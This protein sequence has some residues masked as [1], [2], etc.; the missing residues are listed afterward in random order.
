MS[1][2]V[3]F[4]IRSWPCKAFPVSVTLVDVSFMTALSENLRG[5]LFWS[6]DVLVVLIDMSC[7][8]VS[9]FSPIEIK[10]NKK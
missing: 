8:A 1:S 6:S 3:F 2:F 10:T 9:H 4:L 7:S 5:S